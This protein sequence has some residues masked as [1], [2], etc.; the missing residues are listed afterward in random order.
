V[1][2][3][4]PKRDADFLDSRD[5]QPTRNRQ[6]EVLSGSHNMGGVKTED[7]R[8]DWPLISAQSD[9]RIRS[10]CSATR[11]SL[12]LSGIDFSFAPCST[13][14]VPR[15]P[16]RQVS[17]ALLHEPIY[18]APLCVFWA[19]ACVT[20]TFPRLVDVL[21]HYLIFSPNFY[22]SILFPFRTEYN[23]ILLSAIVSLH[24]I[25]C[26]TSRHP[27]GLSHLFEDPRSYTSYLYNWSRSWLVFKE[28]L[29]L[30]R[31]DLHY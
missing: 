30:F 5:R 4:W 7:D 18:E 2:L 25:Y 9:F 6:H 15:R 20:N 28:L 14:D 10:I 26:I 16:D 24:L 22:I 13:R 11:P 8:D 1:L 31:A 21:T 27:F 17:L 12:L 3:G 23:C 19:S 29:T